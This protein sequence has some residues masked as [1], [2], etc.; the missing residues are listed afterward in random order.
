V[1]PSP[2]ASHKE[3]NRMPVLRTN[4]E[5]TV[6]SRMETRK[7]EG[8]GIRGMKARAVM[9]KETMVV[10]REMTSPRVGT[11]SRA[12]G[13]GKRETMP[14]VMAREIVRE[15]R[16]TMGRAKG[17]GTRERTGKVVMRTAVT[18]AMVGEM[19]SLG[20]TLGVNPGERVAKITITIL[21]RE[22]TTTSLVGNHKEMGGM[23]S[24][25]T[26]EIRV[27]TRAVGIISKVGMGVAITMMGTTV[28]KTRERRITRPTNPVMTSTLVIEGYT[29]HRN[30]TRRSKST[31]GD[32]SNRGATVKMT[33]KLCEDR[34]GPSNVLE[35]FV[36]LLSIDDHISNPNVATPSMIDCL[37]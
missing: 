22:G 29:F 28:E 33:Q 26:P 9:R 18:T 37:E 35:L 6:I 32:E 14:T 17:T 24:G 4:L 21:D 23:V 36:G 30:D 31:I 12:E 13:S 11:T 3:R 10:A 5:M 15:V 8:S 19:T 2:T 34:G 1:E 20:I 25:T 7:V 16:E 27:G